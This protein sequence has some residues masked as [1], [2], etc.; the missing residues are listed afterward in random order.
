MSAPYFL[1]S[2]INFF[3]VRFT[4]HAILDDGDVGIQRT[5]VAKMLQ[6]AVFPDII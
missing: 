4:D 5:R 6:N 3:Q 1:Y 2:M